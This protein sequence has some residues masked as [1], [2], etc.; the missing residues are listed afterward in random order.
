MYMKNDFL[1]IVL[2]FVCLL[3][4]S[5]CLDNDDEVEIVNYFLAVNLPS[6]LQSTDASGLNVT[7]KNTLTG[8]VQVLSTNSQG[9]VAFTGLPGI[10]NIEVTGQKTYSFVNSNG[11]TIDRT[12]SLAGI[13][14]NVALTSLSTNL[15]MDA[16]MQIASKGWVIKEIYYT[17]S[18][19]P[20]GGAY[21]KDQFVE[22]YNNTDS[23]LYADGIS[24][25]QTANNTQSQE[26]NI[27]ASDID[28]NT[29]V[30]TVYTIPGSGKD[31]PVQPGKSILLAPQP[32]NHKE[33]NENSFDLSTANYQWYDSHATLSIDVPE[34]PNMEKYYSYSATIWI[35]HNRGYVSFIA[36]RAPKATGDYVTE[37]TDIRN[38]NSGNSVTAIRISNDDILDAVELGSKSDFKSKSL[39]SSL[40]IGYTYCSGSGTAKSVR[41]KIEKEEEDG[42]VVYKDTNNS[43]LDFIP[44]ATPMPKVFTAESN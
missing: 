22:L 39:S 29:Y 43:A 18:K 27:Y 41:R 34:V 16:V 2:A 9:T 8:S 14:E 33:L 25:A 23:V 6:D 38:N 15:T 32:I 19:T 1:K 11:E 31:V 10:Y 13:R 30:N 44:D 20:S 26:I 37:N 42:R 4:F 28:Q 36:F 24:I 7:F 21:N 3:S 17:G 35:L 12:V 40:D 5:S